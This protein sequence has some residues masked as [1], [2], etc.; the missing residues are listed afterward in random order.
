MTPRLKERYQKEVVEKVKEK[1]GIKNALAVPRLDKIVINMGVGKAI[2]DMKILD[3]AVK[4][5]ENFTGQ[6][7]VITRA[8]I[9]ISNFKLRANM[10]IGC[11]VTL[12][13]AKMY[14]FLDRL[15]S[16]CLPRIRDFNGVSKKSFDKNGNYTLGISDQAIFPEV[17]QSKITVPQ[18]MDITIVFN[19]GPKEQTMEVLRLLGMP[20]AKDKKQEE[21]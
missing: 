19:K 10:P 15:I 16:I 6:K 3:N 14:E 8:R 1:F 2:A 4:D 21:E 12:R 17:D 11:K 7:A 18:G 20:F 9:A 13:R 5:L